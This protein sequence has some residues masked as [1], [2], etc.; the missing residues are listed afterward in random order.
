MPYIFKSISTFSIFLDTH[1][2]HAKHGYSRFFRAITRAPAFYF[3][4]H[5]NEGH[6]P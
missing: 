5:V 2:T 1:N 3:S 4:L 6:S